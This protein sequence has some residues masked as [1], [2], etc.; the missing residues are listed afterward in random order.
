MMEKTYGKRGFVTIATGHQRY[1]RLAQN[2]LLSYHQF[3]TELYPFAII[4]DREN[5]ITAQ[6]DHVIVIS[7]ASNSYNDKLKLFREL[8]YEET[9]FIDADSLAYGDLDAW[10]SIF[11]GAGDFSLFGYAWRDLTCGRGWF[12]PDGMKEYREDISF[13]PDFNGGVY[14]MRNTPACGRV[15]EIANRCVAHYSE[16]CFNGF[17]TPADEPVLALGM[18]VC[19]F[20]PVNLDGELV[21]APPLK[22]LDADISV[23]RA[24]FHKTRETAYPVRLIHFSNYRTQ[25]SFYRNEVVKLNRI[26]RGGKPSEGFLR[27]ADMLRYFIFRIEDMIPLAKRI[28]RKIKRMMQT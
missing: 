11:S 24:V 13:I 19:G 15:F 16:Y 21:F 23:P 18:A 12:V 2:L 5:E 17:R 20:E 3:A 6:F 28:L 26:S 4:A 7:D 1:Y 22:K 10:W 9:I 14:Y 27:E 25:L 8:P